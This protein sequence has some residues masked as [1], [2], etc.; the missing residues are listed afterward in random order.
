MMRIKYE[1]GQDVAHVWLPVKERQVAKE[2]EKALKGNRFAILATE[3]EVPQD[4]T[5]RAQ[6]PQVRAKAIN[7][8]TKSRKRKE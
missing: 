4:F 7:T 8:E 6:V 1:Q 3:S 5:R 2:T